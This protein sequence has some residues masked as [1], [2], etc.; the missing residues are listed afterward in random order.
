[1][2]Q[3]C[4]T[5]LVL[6]NFNLFDIP[7]AGTKSSCH[8]AILPPCYTFLPT[9]KKPELSYLTLGILRDFYLAGLKIKLLRVDSF[10]WHRLGQCNHWWRH[11]QH[12]YLIEIYKGGT[13]NNS[14]SKS[15]ETKLFE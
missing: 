6:F 5:R 11:G 1:M 4:D 14:K 15:F 9:I 7:G 3:K 12:A 10:N 8:L 2:I 13:C